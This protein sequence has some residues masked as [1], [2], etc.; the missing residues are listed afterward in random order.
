MVAALVGLRE[1]IRRDPGPYRNLVHYFTNILKQARRPRCSAALLAWRRLVPRSCRVPA[2][3]CCTASPAVP[4]LASPAVAAPAS[5]ALPPAPPTCPP[6]PAPPALP[7]SPRPPPP[8]A[9]AAEGK[10]GRPY[11]YHRAP[12]PFVQLELL[13]LLA[14]LGAGDKGA[15]ENVYAVV[16][17]VKRRAEPL[18]N[19]IGAAAGPGGRRGGAPCDDGCRDG[20]ASTWGPPHCAPPAALPLAAPPQATRWC[21]SA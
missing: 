12:A 4:A 6:P 7:T 15:S 2:R 19:N 14:L 16:A 3:L 17:E 21:L 20:A 10:L 8:P 11:E 1:L 18:G 9:Q 13:R 5:P